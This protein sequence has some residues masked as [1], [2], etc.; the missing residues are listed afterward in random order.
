MSSFITRS[1]LVARF[2]LTA[3]L[4][5]SLAVSLP[6][7]AQDGAP[8]AAVKSVVDA[9]LDI[10]RSPG[11]DLERDRP[12]IRTEIRRAF[13][14]T[15]M[16]Q[17]VL[18]T[19]WR[20]ASKEQ[21][22]EFKNLLSQT[23]EGTYIGRLRAFSNETVDFGKEDIRENRATV[24]TVI[25]SPSGDIPIIYK[26][27]LRNDGW[28]VYDVEIENVSMVS[29]YRD[30]YRSIVRRDGMDG[31]LQQMRDKV[32]ELEAQANLETGV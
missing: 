29:T 14:D 4:C 1:S 17:S 19:N 23:I 25:R 7:N 26:L 10:L 24:N 21:Q 32:T 27:R 11:F 5:S 15:A 16:A 30:T 12:T 2:L 9:I 31:L 20:Q 3:V 28:F 13:D 22:D 18:S 8:S 6:A